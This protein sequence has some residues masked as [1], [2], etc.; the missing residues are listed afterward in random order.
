MR[1]LIA[2]VV[3]LTTC[4]VA[5]VRAQKEVIHFLNGM[6]EDKIEAISY[7]KMRRDFFV[8]IEK[9]GSNKQLSF[10]FRSDD[11][12]SVYLNNTLVTSQWIKYSEVASASYNYFVP[13]KVKINNN[14]NCVIVTLN[15]KKKFVK[16][17]LNKSYSF[18]SIYYLKGQ[19]GNFHWTVIHSNN[20]P[21]G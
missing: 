7:D 18:I 1:R 21:A 9:R 6:R 2:I 10:Y 11:S 13:F 5:N 20:M 16:F 17:K 15:Q 19:D 8:P 14:R 4:F 12:I 3:I